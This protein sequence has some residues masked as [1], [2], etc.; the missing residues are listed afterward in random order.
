MSLGTILIVVVGFIAFRNAQT[1][2]ITSM[3]APMPTH[4]V[5]IITGF[6]FAVIIGTL[7][8]FNIGDK[9]EQKCQ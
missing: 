6:I 8:Y 5:I 3:M 9:E 2:D 4:M 1:Q 7:I